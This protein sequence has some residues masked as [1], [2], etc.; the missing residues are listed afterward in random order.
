MSDHF[1][2]P[3]D[4]GVA[5]KTSWVSGTPIGQ[6]EVR[7]PTLGDPAEYGNPAERMNF[8]DEG[9]LFRG[10]RVEQCPPG[11][12][13]TDGVCTPDPK[14]EA[15]LASKMKAAI[16]HQW[17]REEGGKR[18]GPDPSL[19]R[20]LPEAPMRGIVSKSVAKLAKGK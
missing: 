10:R 4:W 1:D 20:D 17:D 3:S 2:K 6:S 19:K 5:P 18:K 12:T 8:G 14:S 9:A 16:G 15:T 11:L 13:N 7:M